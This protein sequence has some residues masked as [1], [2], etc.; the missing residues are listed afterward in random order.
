M[1]QNRIKKL[2]PIEHVLKRPGMYIGTIT[3]VKEDIFFIGEDGGW[4]EVEYI[5]GFLKIIYEVLDNSIDEGIRTDFQFANKISITVFPNYIEIED[6]G[7]GLPREMIGETPSGIVALTETMAGT[8]FD[9]DTKAND[10]IGMNG[11]GATLTNIF[12]NDFQM[13]SYDGET[14]LSLHCSDNLSTIKWRLVKNKSVSGTKIIF[15][16]DL[17]FFGMKEIE[18]IYV[19]LIEQRLIHVAQTHD[20]EFTLNSYLKE[21]DVKI[22]F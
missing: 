15:E 17:E 19:D 9:E 20:I 21:K 13:K 4:K 5:P 8:N 18:K 7:R 14:L 10:S 6:N 22:L 12:S 16:P 3:N 1:K 11:V 2:S